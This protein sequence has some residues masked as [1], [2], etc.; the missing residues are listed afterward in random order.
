MN[1]YFTFDFSWR[2]CF[3]SVLVIVFFSG[4]PSE[5]VESEVPDEGAKLPEK[6]KVSVKAEC[7][8]PAWSGF[9]RDSW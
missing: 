9:A 4:K 3:L 8:S 6:Y 7:A 1:N 2:I 5:A